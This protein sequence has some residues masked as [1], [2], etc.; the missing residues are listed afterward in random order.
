MHSDEYFPGLGTL[1]TSSKECQ[2]LSETWHIGLDNYI[3]SSKGDTRS[4]QILLSDFYPVGMSYNYLVLISDCDGGEEAEVHFDKVDLGTCGGGGEESCVRY[5]PG[6]TVSVPEGWGGDMSPHSQT[7]DAKVRVMIWQAEYAPF[8]DSGWNV[9]SAYRNSYMTFA[10]GVKAVPKRVKVLYR[11]DPSD[12]MGALCDEKVLFEGVG[13]AHADDTD[14]YREYGGALFAVDSTEVR[15]WAPDR[16]VPSSAEVSAGLVFIDNGWGHPS[17]SSSIYAQ[18]G[19][20][21]VLV[22]KE[23]D[24]FMM[25]DEKLVHVNLQDLN[26]PPEP[27]SLW[28]Q[29]DENIA[30]GEFLGEI[31]VED[32]QGRDA[33]TF[34]LVR[35]NIF[36][37][38]RFDDGLVYVANATVFNYEFL[39]FQ[40]HHII[41]E[42]LV[43]DGFN[44]VAT[45]V[46]ISVQDVN[47]IPVIIPPFEREIIEGSPNNAMVGLSVEATDEDAYQVRS[48]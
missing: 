19:E 7:D 33:I 43:S 27:Q 36:N 2:C 3:T 45:S 8:Y 28:I 14:A 12:C 1:A 48:K 24:E 37:A 26:E 21:R 6:H 17:G 10:H 5:K 16:S 31:G 34:E 11:A 40:S 32:D 25:A 46:A 15:V 22:W 18:G 42:I 4:Y 23:D 13:F 44:N 39:E 9:L 29:V 30:E 20:V 47:D 38:V 35:G 41:L